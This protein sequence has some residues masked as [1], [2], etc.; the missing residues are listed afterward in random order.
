MS[1]ASVLLPQRAPYTDP[2]A[3]L[4]CGGSDSKIGLDNCVSIQ[5]E[6]ANPT[7]V[8]ERMVRSILLHEFPD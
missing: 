7:W 5:P 6:S 8:I 4:I 3:V 1:G 2:I